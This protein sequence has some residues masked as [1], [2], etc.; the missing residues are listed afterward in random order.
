MVANAGSLIYLYLLRLRLPVLTFLGTGAWFF[1]AV[2]LVKV[3]LS[4][5]L[6]LVTGRTLL[7]ALVLAPAVAVGAV[8][9]RAIVKKLSLE[10][11]EWFVLV[12]TLAAAVNLVR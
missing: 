7:L 11:F 6:G 1:F 8:V 9:G 12:V 10:V 5:S 3:P 4:V 2:N